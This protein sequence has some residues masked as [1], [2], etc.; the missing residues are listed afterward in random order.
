MYVTNKSY[1]FKIKLLKLQLLQHIWCKWKT[2]SAHSPCSLCKLTSWGYDKFLEMH[3]WQCW[4]PQIH[5]Q[6]PFVTSTLCEYMHPVFLRNFGVLLAILFIF[7]TKNLAQQLSPKRG[8]L[9]LM[10][11]VCLIASS[12]LSSLSKRLRCFK[13]WNRWDR[14]PFSD[15]RTRRGRMSQCREG[16]PDLTALFLCLLGFLT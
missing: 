5:L 12:P 4:I 7:Q 10:P 8:R 14:L 1:F 2:T 3:R 13:N 16:K 6:H 15:T 9:F 11:L